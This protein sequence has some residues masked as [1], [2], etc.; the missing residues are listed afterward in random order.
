MLN[1][2]PTLTVLIC[3]HSQSDFYDFLLLESIK[4]LETQTYKEFETLIVLDECWENT[5]K[6][7]IELNTNLEITI[8]EKEKRNGLYDAKN[9]GLSFISTDLVAFL[10]ADDLYLP[11]KLEIQIQF[12]KNNKVD[13]LGTCRWEFL[14]DINNLIKTFYE[15]ERYVTHED[16]FMNIK[17][18]VIYQMMLYLH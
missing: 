10:D 5:K 1:K 17:D 2:N 11:N 4:S 16:I 13:F 6:R 7:I 12:F 14:D 8:K 18:I 9:F 3:V 15:L